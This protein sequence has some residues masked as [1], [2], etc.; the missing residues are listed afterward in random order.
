MKEFAF[1]L[2]SCEPC[3]MAQAQPPASW[4]EADWTNPSRRWQAYQAVSDWNNHDCLYVVFSQHC[5]LAHSHNVLKSRNVRVNQKRS[6]SIELQLTLP[7]V[8]TQLFSASNSC[9]IGLQNDF[10]LPFLKEPEWWDIQITLQFRGFDQIHLYS[11]IS[12]FKWFVC[13]ELGTGILEWIKLVSNTFQSI[14]W[15]WHFAPCPIKERLFTSETTI[16]VRNNE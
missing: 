3:V 4:W 11:A 1:L 2:C 12:A 15:V 10:N 9:R 8:C 13:H 14:Y 6:Y 5:T 7:G 16:H